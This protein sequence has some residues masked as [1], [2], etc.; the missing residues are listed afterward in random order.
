M[1]E[2][3]QR[4]SD[5]AVGH[6]KVES[7]AYAHLG[8][9]VLR[10]DD[11]KARRGHHSRQPMAQIDQPDMASG[12]SASLDANKRGSAINT[13]IHAKDKDHYL[14]FINKGHGRAGHIQ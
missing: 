2:D 11:N 5:A 6:P 12:D 10:L 7:G 13:R 14:S 1:G 4:A 3:R 8:R 9:G